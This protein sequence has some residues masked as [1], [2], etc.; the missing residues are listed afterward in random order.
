[1][2]GFST[3]TPAFLWRAFLFATLAGGAA[4]ALRAAP[5]NLPVAPDL[6]QVGKP[7]AAAARAL[8]EKFRESSLPGRYYFEFE[9][10]ALPRRGEER[11]Y[12]GRLWGARNDQGAI[13]RVQLTDAAGATHRWLL[14]NGASAS[15]WTLANGQPAQ[16]A[17]TALFAPL[18][19]GVDVSAF[20]LLM[21]YL[22]WPDA[23][24][25]RVERIRGRPAH[26]YR[27]QPPAAFARAHPEIGSVRA[28]LDTQFNALMQAERCG[29]DGQVLATLSLGELK[30]VDEQW[31]L[32][33]VDFRNEATRNKTRLL[34]T[35]VA[36]NLDLLPALFEPAGLA[37]ELAPPRAD[38]IVRLA[39]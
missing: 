12:R 14:Q 15:V 20:D 8:L 6:A 22:Y 25:D 11:V 29:P 34:V 2:A 1:M 10:H 37:D 4:T 33:S 5:P 28:Y 3:S 27:F 21:P 13:T 35:A 30:K 26:A 32:K 38:R 18:I 19:P 31:L 36:L 9:L 16:L 39:P 23:A 24:L 7:D 17:E